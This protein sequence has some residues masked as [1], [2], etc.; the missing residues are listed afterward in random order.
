MNALGLYGVQA[1]PQP[2]RVGLL[3]RSALATLPKVEYIVSRILPLGG[4]IGITGQPSAKKTFFALDMACSIARG[5]NF[6]GRAVSE[7]H[8]VYIAAEGARGLHKRLLAWE[9]THGIQQVPDERLAFVPEA[10]TLNNPP[11]LRRPLWRQ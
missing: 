4:L 6:L 11:H 3:P 5:V 2:R 10:V 7:G 8:V 9:K 1:A